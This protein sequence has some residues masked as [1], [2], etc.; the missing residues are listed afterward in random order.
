MTDEQILSAIGYDTADEAMK[1]AVIENI[2]TIVELRVVGVVSEQMSDE[3]LAAF[4]SLQESGD[5]Q[6][7]W[8]WLRSDVVGVDVSEV[9]EAILKDYIDQFL[10]DQKALG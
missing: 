7:I 9:Y 8:Q 10:E 6:A 2:R 1:Q 4:T 5:N 3:Q